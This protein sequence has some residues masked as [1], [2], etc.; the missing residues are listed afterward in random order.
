VKHKLHLNAGVGMHIQQC[1]TIK[2]WKIYNG[3][4]E[5]I[6][7]VIESGRKMTIGVKFEVNVKKGIMKL[8]M[9]CCSSYFK[10]KN[11]KKNNECEFEYL[12][13]IMSK[14][15]PHYVQYLFL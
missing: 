1:I 6:S 15:D 13:L 9:V 7:F 14:D 12:M 10:V 5:V 3:K 8:F 11:Y 2:V 4:I